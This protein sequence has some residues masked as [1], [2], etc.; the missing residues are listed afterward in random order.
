[1]Y[2]L[3]NKH[4]KNGRLHKTTTKIGTL[5][6]N[7]PYM[8]WISNLS[9]RLQSRKMGVTV[10]QIT[11]C[12][13]FQ[14]CLWACWHNLL[15]FHFLNPLKHFALNNKER[16]TWLHSRFSFLCN[17]KALT[18]ILHTYCIHVSQECCTHNGKT[19]PELQMTQLSLLLSRLNR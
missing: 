16:T 3:Y 15:S 18:C 13:G 12:V 4:M 1:M 6:S 8:Q 17:P 14:F 19:A 9:R 7:I 5:Q 10:G 11:L 2:R